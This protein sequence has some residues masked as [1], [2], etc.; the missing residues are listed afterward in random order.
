[1]PIEHGFV[2]GYIVN[3]SLDAGWEVEIQDAETQSPVASYQTD[4]VAVTRYEEL[5]PNQAYRVRLRKSDPSGNSAWSEWLEV[6]TLGEGYVVP[7]P[8]VRGVLTGPNVLAL[9]IEPPLRA[10]RYFVTARPSG[11]GDVIS[12]TIERSAVD[13][14]V[15]DGLAA[16]TGYD[17]SLRVQTPSGLS[18]PTALS[19]ST[20]Q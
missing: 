10:E 17:V 3:N 9:R 12:R 4:V 19:G 6:Q 15:I 7:P 14:L 5:E 1:V 11:G 13:A 2:L 18:Q 20:R 16:A 8:T